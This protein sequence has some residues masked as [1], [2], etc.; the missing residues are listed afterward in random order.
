MANCNSFNDFNNF[1]GFIFKTFPR[2]ARQVVKN[3]LRDIMKIQWDPHVSA[4]H[5]KSSTDFARVSACHGK[6]ANDFARVSACHGKSSRDLARVSTCHGKS[7]KDFAAVSNVT[8]N[9][10]HFLC[11]FVCIYHSLIRWVIYVENFEFLNVAKFPTRA[12]LI[13]RYSIIT[14]TFTK[15]KHF[16]VTKT[17]FQFWNFILEDISGKNIFFFSFWD[18][19]IK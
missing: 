10:K 14:W 8:K 16:H 5:G 15:C 4:C 11:A 12:R 2:C 9:M 17:F 6:S 19:R 7:S 1:V 13:I 18:R 3:F